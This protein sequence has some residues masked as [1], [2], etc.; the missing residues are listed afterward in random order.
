[1]IEAG[2]KQEWLPGRQMNKG[3]G[4]DSDELL[5]TASYPNHIKTGN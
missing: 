5:N 3:Y 2:G 4:R 1:M